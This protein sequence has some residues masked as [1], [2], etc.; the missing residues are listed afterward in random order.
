MDF[1]TKICGS[2]QSEKN[3]KE[4]YLKKNGYYSSY[5]KLCSSENSKKN[6]KTRMEKY[7]KLGS[8]E[9]RRKFLKS[10][11]N[12]TIEQYNN[13]FEAQSGKCAI[14]KKH[15]SEYYRAFSVDHCHKTGKVRGLLC[16][17]CNAAIGLL[18]DNIN[19]IEA[20]LHYLIYNK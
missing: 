5:C 8:D 17:D 2:C 9:L 13:L 11:Y 7:G 15:Q 3:V 4:F 19:N 18:K 1:E 12:L 16:N 20:A 14:C 10:K 6:N